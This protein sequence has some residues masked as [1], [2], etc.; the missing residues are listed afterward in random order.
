MHTNNKSS[1]SNEYFILKALLL[2]TFTAIIF[3]IRFL[4]FEQH[5]LCLYTFLNKIFEPKI[6]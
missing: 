4:I 2:F 5:H 6:M 1:Y 3:A